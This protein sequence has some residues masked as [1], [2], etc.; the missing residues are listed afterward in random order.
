MIATVFVL[1]FAGILYTYK[2]FTVAARIGRNEEIFS[3]NIVL[4]SKNATIV[5]NELTTFEWDKV[6]FFDPYVSKK[7]IYETIGFYWNG[8]QQQTREDSMQIL[9]VNKGNVV[10]YCS[11]SGMDNGYFINGDLSESSRELEKEDD[12][13]LTCDSALS[14]KLGYICLKIHR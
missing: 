3:S 1:V 10:C 7:E 9:F 11:G 14:D 8:I 13:V 5:L 6:Y 2:V 12:P 4:A